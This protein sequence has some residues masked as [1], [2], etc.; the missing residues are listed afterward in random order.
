MAWGWHGDVRPCENK[1]LWHTFSIFPN[2]WGF[3][4]DVIVNNG[5]I[6]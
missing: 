2:I 5:K 4:R 1:F 6:L 3:V